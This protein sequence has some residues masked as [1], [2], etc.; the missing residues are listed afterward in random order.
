[1]ESDELNEKKNQKSNT[2]NNEEKEEIG[3]K[4]CKRSEILNKLNAPEVKIRVK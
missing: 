2:E 1:M 3:D 4:T